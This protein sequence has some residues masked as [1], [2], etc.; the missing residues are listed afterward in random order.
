MNERSSIDFKWLYLILAMANLIPILFVKYPAGL[1]LP[2]HTLAAALHSFDPSDPRREYFHVQWISSPYILFSLLMFPLLKLFGYLTALKIVLS[3]VIVAIPLSALFF[4]KV[5]KPRDWEFAFGSFLFLFTFHFEY[6]F[7]PY[8]MGIP[9]VLLG[10]AF[11][12]LLIQGPIQRRLTIITSVVIA[13]AY[14]SHII[15]ILALILGAAVL[16]VSRPDRQDHLRE[17]QHVNRYDKAWRVAATFLPALLLFGLFMAQLPDAGASGAQALAAMKYR[18]LFHQLQGP[19]RVFF[20]VNPIFDVVMMSCVLSVI[21][22]LFLLRKLRWVGGVPFWLSATYVAVILLMPRV[23]FLG[24]TDLSSRLALFG[25]LSLLASLGFVSRGARNALIA[26]MTLFVIANVSFRI[27]YYSAVSRLTE[28]YV[29]ATEEH[30]PPRQKVLTTHCGFP[31]S[32]LRPLLHAIGWYHVEKGG[33]SPF[34]LYEN[35]AATGVSTTVKLPALSEEWE[36]RDTL[37]LNDV[38]SHYDYFVATTCGSALPQSLTQLR[39]PVLFQDSVCT[40]WKVSR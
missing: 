9:L 26:V 12:R 40:I 18:S 15:N 23:R 31:S 21:A 7:I 39:D 30:I 4:M 2:N 16:I 28:Q 36:D 22:A 29:Q 34:L 14:L 19:I 25:S 32:K 3:M 1:D 27:Q 38:L 13:L 10:L 35:P 33:V 5:F 6:G 37:K 20:S 11:L 8:L 17:G 24:G